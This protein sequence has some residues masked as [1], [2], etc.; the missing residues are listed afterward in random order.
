MTRIHEIICK[1]WI[2]PRW[3]RGIVLYPFIF[4]QG[5]PTPELRRHEWV[6]VAQIR[7][8]GAVVFYALYL[9]YNITRGYERNPFEVEARERATTK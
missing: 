8:H 6:H 5:N 4:Y 3:I 2:L 1:R 7:R 9:F